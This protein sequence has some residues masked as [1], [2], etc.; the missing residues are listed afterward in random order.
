MC[1]ETQKKIKKKKKQKRQKTLLFWGVGVEVK[2]MKRK[3][4]GI[5]IKN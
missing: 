5:K 1:V 4:T 2:K 3:A